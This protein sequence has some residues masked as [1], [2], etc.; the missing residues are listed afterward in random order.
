MPIA[1]LDGDASGGL[2]G[3]NGGGRGSVGG[4]RG[5]SAGGGGGPGGACTPESKTDQLKQGN[6]HCLLT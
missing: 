1:R 2:A 4:G 5:G 6:T 3:G